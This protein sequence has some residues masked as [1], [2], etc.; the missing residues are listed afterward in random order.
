MNSKIV[1]NGAIGQPLKIRIK[2]R[3]EICCPLSIDLLTTY[4]SLEQEDWFEDEI[5]FVRHMMKPGMKV[6]DIGANFGLYTLTMANRIGPEGKVWAFEPTSITASFLNESITQNRFTNTNL[7]QAALSNFTGETSLHSSPHSELNSLSRKLDFH[8]D[9]ETVDLLTLDHC[10][11]EYGWDDIDFVKLDAEGEEINIINGGKEFFQTQS[12]LIMFEVK[13]HKTIDLTLMRYFIELG[14]TP[15]RL[16]PGLNML[17]PFDASEKID[18]YQLNLFSC[19]PD[20]A[21]LLEKRNLLSNNGLDDF[22]PEFECNEGLWSNYLSNFAYAGKLRE[23]WFSFSKP[24]TKADWLQYEVALNYYALAH[25][26]DI[27]P[28]IRHASLNNAFIYLI[29]L[30]QTA[31]T[32]S[33]LQTYTRILWE[34]GMRDHSFRMLNQLINMITSEIQI[35]F[36]EPFVPVSA[37]FDFID[38]EDEISKWCYASLM[39]QREILQAFSS[40]YTGRYSAPNLNALM[41]LEFQNAEMERR[42]QLVRIRCGLQKGPEYNYLLAT[43]SVD[44]LNPDFWSKNMFV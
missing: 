36:D 32:F 33:R 30:C 16:I 4:V 6:I 40:Y 22:T 29:K 38:P 27:P 23:N 25:S 18:P 35:N 10:C 24:Q 31:P 34:L 9:Y 2:D 20:R 21:R 15:Y 43:E 17:I 7:I 44:N 26:P 14:Y 8:S 19:R 5:K 28:A 41:K 1:K 3:I 12:P 39:E 13:D 11:E 37:R 42:R